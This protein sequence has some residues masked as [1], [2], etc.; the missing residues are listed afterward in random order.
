MDYFIESERKIPVVGKF[1]VI[2]V[3]GGVA[4]IAASIAAARN[5]ANT[6]LI[7]RDGCLGGTATVGLMTEFQGVNFSIVK[8]IFLEVVEELKLKE[9][10]LIGPNSPFDPEIFKFVTEQL[11]INA[12]CKILYHTMFTKTILNNNKVTGIIVESKEGR[13]AL[14][15]KTIIDA[16]GDADVVASIGALFEKGNN[17]QP[18]TSVFRMNHVDIKKLI[19]YIENNPEQF[20]FEPGQKTWLIDQTPPL[21]TIGGFKGLIEEARKKGELYLPHDSIWLCSMP[22]KGEISVNATRVIDVDGTTSRDLSMAEIDARKQIWS[23]SNFLKKYVPGFEKA[24][25][26]DCGTR[27]GVRESRR[28]IGEYKLTKEDLLSGKKFTDT[29]ATY[30]FPMDIQAYNEKKESHGWIL[31]PNPYDIPLRCLIP[32]NI[33]GLLVC[34]RCISTDHEA[35]GSTRSMPCCMAT[36]QAAGTVGALVGRKNIPIRSVNVSE[37]QE[38]LQEQGVILQN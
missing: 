16:S 12:G 6:A 2:I 5:G 33:D 17:L 19:R 36:G 38:I 27:I 11:V 34:G 24:R 26:L 7:E 35:H 28:I 29:I 3:G 21:F 30:K 25:L 37:I 31:V 14:F 32:K 23:V 10:I 18:A 4:G 1:D 22:Q 13:S 15:A 9:G 8:G 20:Y